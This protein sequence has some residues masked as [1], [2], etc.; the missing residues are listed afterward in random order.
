MV[1]VL[2]YLA[3][4]NLSPTHHRVQIKHAYQHEAHCLIVCHT[5]DFIDNGWFGR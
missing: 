4:Y 3:K 5:L 2:V 1:C